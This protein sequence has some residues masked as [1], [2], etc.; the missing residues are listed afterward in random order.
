MAYNP[1]RCDEDAATAPSI[2]LPTNCA[3]WDNISLPSKGSARF[4]TDLSRVVRDF[5]DGGNELKPPKR[6]KKKAAARGSSLLRRAALALC[7]GRCR[8]LAVASLVDVPLKHAVRRL[9]VGPLRLSLHTPCSLPTS[10]H[11]ASRSWR[12]CAAGARHRAHGRGAAS[13]RQAHRAMPAVAL[14]PTAPPPHT[15]VP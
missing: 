13:R 15:H 10:L 14:P 5:L 6:A 4:P 9:S 2:E 8:W 7:G 12:R 1:E 11:G 3:R